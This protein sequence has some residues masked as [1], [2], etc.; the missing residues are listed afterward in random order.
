MLK[1]EGAFVECSA[2]TLE[3]GQ[4]GWV[5][6]RSFTGG[7]DLLGPIQ[8]LYGRYRLAGSNPEALRQV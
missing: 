3:Q 5:Q 8:K 1:L 2:E 4:A 6:S 7:I